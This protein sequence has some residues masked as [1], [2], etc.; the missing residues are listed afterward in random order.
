MTEWTWKYKGTSTEIIQSEWW[1]E[2]KIGKK[3]KDIHTHTQ[4]NKKNPQTKKQQKTE[5]AKKNIIEEIMDKQTSNLVKD[6]NLYIREAQFK[7]TENR[8]RVLSEHKGI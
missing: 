8:Q 3:T 4:T 6:M 2:K 1:R 5:P 7:R